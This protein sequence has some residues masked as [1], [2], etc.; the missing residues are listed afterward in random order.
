MTKHPVQVVTLMPAFVALYDSC[1]PKSSVGNRG[2]I[3]E[4]LNFLS[5]YVKIDYLEVIY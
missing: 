5:S 2:G 3:K 4:E 1:H